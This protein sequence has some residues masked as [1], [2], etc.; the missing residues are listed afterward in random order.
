MNIKKGMEKNGKRGEKR[1]CRA[2]ERRRQEE[3]RGK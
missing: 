3:E 1:E 2:G